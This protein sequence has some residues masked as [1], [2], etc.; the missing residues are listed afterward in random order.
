MRP[1]MIRRLLLSTMATLLLAGCGGAEDKSA[2]A[3]A[4]G[5][6]QSGGPGGGRRGPQGPAEVGFI[7]IK[8]GDVPIITELAGRTAAYEVSEVRPQVSG[9]LQARLFTEGSLVRKGQP[10]YQ[11]DPRLY[12]AAQAQARANLASSQAT[13]QAAKVRADRYK[14]L[15]DMEAISKQDYTDAVATAGQATASVAQ[16]RAAL[17]TAGINLGFTRILAPISGR[18]G[19]SLVTTGALVT[20]GQ[21]DPLAT[22]QRLDPMFVDIQ[23]SSVE[24]LALRK[25]AATPGETVARQAR[26]R[27]VLEDGS[28]YPIEGMLEFAEAVV[29]PTTGTVTLRARFPNP[30]GLLLPGMFVHARLSQVTARDAILVP[31]QAVA[32]DP[33]GNATVYV[34]GAGNKAELRTITAARTIGENWLVTAG[35][36]PGD[37]VITE[38]LNR[39]RPGGVVRPVPAGSKPTPARRRPGGGE[40]GN[41]GESGGNAARGA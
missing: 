27:L 16:T 8:T 34:V 20:T 14:P 37:R 17:E 1:L 38:G 7:V 41:A 24:L 30:T 22:I 28:V 10:L 13:Q 35:L 12:R 36:Q 21:A 19:R 29:D 5:G 40:G 26:V 9:I 31:Q 18:I 11:I 23:Q 32:R 3:G 33:K 39:L 15:A 2:Q 4:G 25:A 6:A